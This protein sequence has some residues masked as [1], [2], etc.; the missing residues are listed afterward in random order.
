MKTNKGF[1]LIEMLVVIGVFSVL[2]IVSAQSIIVSLSGAKRSSSSTKVRENLEFAI[3]TI[4]R[5]IRN[6]QAISCV[7]SAR[8][9]YE[10]V[11][12]A[13]LGF[14]CLDLTATRNGY[15]VARSATG[16]RN[17]ITDNTI[18]ITSCAFT[19][20]AATGTVPPSLNIRLSAID[21]ASSGVQR[22]TATVNTKIFLRAY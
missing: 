6:S 21:N 4:E 11:N 2:A 14:E 19:C 10:D 18:D 8:V 22:G 3:S 9:D 20:T 12:E 17:A 5:K 16:S 15:L 7:S 1:S 13:T